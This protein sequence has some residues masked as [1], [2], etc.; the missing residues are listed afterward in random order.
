MRAGQEDDYWDCLSGQ[1]LVLIGQWYSKA[2]INQSQLTLVYPN[3]PRNRWTEGL[4]PFSLWSVL[5]QPRYLLKLSRTV[6]WCFNFLPSVG[7]P[8]QTLENILRN[9][10]T[11]NVQKSK[12]NGGTSRKSFVHRNINLSCLPHR[13]E[14]IERKTELARIVKL[15]LSADTPCSI[16]RHFKATLFVPPRNSLCKDSDY[17]GAAV[18]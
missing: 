2:T 1:A 15:M 8:A 3:N 11:K 16:A 13:Y 4:Y 17:I 18:P 10:W 12:L 6:L 14:R 7:T 9:G 5:W